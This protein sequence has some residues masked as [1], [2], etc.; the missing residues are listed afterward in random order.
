MTVRSQVFLVCDYQLPPVCMGRLDI[1]TADLMRAEALARREAY[2]RGW[3]TERAGDG[4]VLDICPRC[5]TVLLHGW[6]AAPGPPPRELLDPPRGPRTIGEAARW[7]RE[8]EQTGH[9]AAPWPRPPG[10][11]HRPGVG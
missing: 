11:A 8:R 2:D 9:Q 10:A 7:A 4:R 5:S 1:L 3:Q 6:D